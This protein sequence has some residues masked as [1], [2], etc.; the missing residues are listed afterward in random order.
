MARGKRLLVG[1]AA[2]KGEV[3]ATVRIVDG[4]AT[5]MAKV[6][7]GEVLVGELFKP[8]HNVYLKK[9][10]ALITDEGGK[11]SHGGVAGTMFGI[12]AVA[13]TVEATKELKDGQKVIVDGNEGAIYEYIPGDD[14]EAKPKPKPVAGGSLADRMAA[15]AAKRGINLPPGF[16]EKQKQKE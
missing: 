9:A 7:P 10:T 5:K 8:E 13:G 16:T 12:P 1:V 2:A 6:L 14:E 3:V 11:L 4:D 15:V